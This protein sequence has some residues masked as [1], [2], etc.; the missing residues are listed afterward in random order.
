MT[1]SC[2]RSIAA[3]ALF[4]FAAV[5]A[6]AQEQDAASYVRS[7]YPPD[8][9]NAAPRYSARTAA[10]WDTCEAVAK[11]NGDAC[12]DFD[13]IVQ[14]NDFELSDIKVEQVSGDADK[15]VVKADFK[16]FGKP[17]TVMFDLIHDK[18]GWAIDEIVSGCNKL[19]EHLQGTSTCMD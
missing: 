16:N 1:G 6:F 13:M 10:L 9:P 19:T 17:V 14:G 18:D 12:M 15:A 7:L 5:P 3:L 8:D 4:V 11:K 2:L